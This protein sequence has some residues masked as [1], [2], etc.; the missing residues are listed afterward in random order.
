MI[1]FIQLY[2]DLDTGIDIDDDNDDEFLSNKDDYALINDSEQI[3]GND[4]DL[5]TGFENVTR[6]LNEPINNH[7]YW[8]DKR[9]L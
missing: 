2:A 5:Q 6:D 3:N 1:E 7:K 9:D 8:L 4:V